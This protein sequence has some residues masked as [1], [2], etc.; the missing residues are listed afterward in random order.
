[1]NKMSQWLPMEPMEV[2]SMLLKLRNME[3]GLSLQ[4]L[5]EKNLLIFL[6]SLFLAKMEFKQHAHFRNGVEALPSL[7]RRKYHVDKIPTRGKKQTRFHFGFK[8]V[9]LN[10]K[11]LLDYENSLVHYTAQ[12]EIA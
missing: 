8:I 3:Y 2:N 6:Q 12:K 9:A 1:M 11:K 10:F 5:P 4:I 7:L